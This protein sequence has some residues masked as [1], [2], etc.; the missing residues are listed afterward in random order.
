[1]ENRQGNSPQ[2]GVELVK[3]SEAHEAAYKAFYNEWIA[4]GENIVPW[5][6]GIDPTDFPAYVRF[7]REAETTAPEGAV[8]HSTYWL[9]DASGAIVGAANIRH[10]LNRKLEEGGGH[11]GYGV[12]PS[13]RRKGYAKAILAR[14]LEVTDRL[15]IRDVLVICDRGNIGSERTI[16][17]GGG[18]FHSEV[19]EENGNIVRRFWI[20]R[21]P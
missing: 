13:Q 6:V 18:Q 12:I 10:R 16:R 21:E 5:V 15:G 3:P 14:A 4:S 20:H 8:T 11:I 9:M 1:M 19:A 2:A 7:L 17:G